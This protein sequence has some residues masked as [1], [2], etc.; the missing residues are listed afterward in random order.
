MKFF[1]WIVE[2]QF[3]LALAS[4]CC[5]TGESSRLIGHCHRRL[6]CC[7]KCSP[8][9]NGDGWSRQ[10]GLLPCFD[11]RFEE[12]EDIEYNVDVRELLQN[13]RLRKSLRTN[14]RLAATP[15]VNAQ[16]RQ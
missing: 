9:Y 11:V 5:R 15:K 4:A 6:P 16:Q 13:A 7:R 10:R 14:K 3:E 1:Y 12:V 2:I 8:W